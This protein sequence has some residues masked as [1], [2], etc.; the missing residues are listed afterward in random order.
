VGGFVVSE[1][2]VGTPVLFHLTHTRHTLLVPV[3]VLVAG[4]LWV[5]QD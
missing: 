5:A 3:H 1:L 4:V 2:Q